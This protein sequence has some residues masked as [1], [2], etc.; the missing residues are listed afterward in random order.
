MNKKSA[1]LFCLLALPF[2]VL[3]SDR[4]TTIFG[5]KIGFSYSKSIFPVSWQEDP[6]SA[7]AEEMDFSEISRVKP[8]AKKALNKYPSILLNTN[9][10]AIY[11]VKRMKFFDVEYGGTNSSRA[12]YVSNTGVEHG[13][14]DSYIEQTIHHEFSSILMRMLFL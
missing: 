13:Y 12:V 8:I 5:V 14:T 7:S 9:L 2:T 4:D 10:S 3:A 1:I 11:F 6:V